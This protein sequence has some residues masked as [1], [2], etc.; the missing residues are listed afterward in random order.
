MKGGDTVL[1]FVPRWWQSVNT[2]LDTTTIPVWALV[3]AFVVVMAYLII[4]MWRDLSVALRDPPPR[5]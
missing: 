1:R 2:W 4:I 5:R 3:V